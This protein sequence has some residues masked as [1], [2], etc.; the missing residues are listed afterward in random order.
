MTDIYTMVPQLDLHRLEITRLCR[1]A[2]EEGAT[3]ESPLS[4]F[5]PQFWD[6]ISGTPA[7]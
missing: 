1:A 5:Y 4:R 7:G 2:L 3:A 6:E